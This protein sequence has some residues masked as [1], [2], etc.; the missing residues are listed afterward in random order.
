MAKNKYSKIVNKSKK[1]RNDP[2][3][4]RQFMKVFILILFFVFLLM[5]L[6]VFT[7]AWF[8]SNKNAV[9]DTIDINVETV[10]G[11][12]IS[13]DAITWDNEITKEELLN[14]SMTYR[15]ALNQFPD[16]LA[17]VS[18]DGSASGGK[19]NI[20]YGIVNEDSHDVYSLYSVKENEINCNGNEECFGHHYVA[21]DIFLLTT[22]PA[23]IGIT[24]NS[25]VKPQEGADDRGSQNAARIG[26]VV[27]GSVD[28]NASAAQSQAIS[29]GTTSYIWE[30][31]YDTHTSYGVAAAKKFYGLTTTTSG[32]NRLPYKGINREFSDHVR[33]DQTDSS[34]YFSTVNPQVATPSVFTTPQ[35]LMRIPAGI[36]KVRVYMWLEGQDVDLEN[37]AANSRLSFDLELS[38]IE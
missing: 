34:P 4:R 29:G 13:H 30:P 22:S 6:G 38:M 18:T 20:Y 32:G 19:M 10:S 31:N 15:S 25:S 28:A 5:N 16:T 8:S 26:F 33:L 37:Q 17:G 12:Q 21:F 24:S 11:L 23:T 35:S 9:I 7:F 1:K 36:T 27:V 3:Y 14:A 2:E